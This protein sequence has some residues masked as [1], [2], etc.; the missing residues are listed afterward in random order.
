MSEP[1]R[2]AVFLD[3]DGT[4]NQDVDFLTEVEQLHILPGVPQALRRLREAGFLLI[5][6][7]NQSAIARG[8]LTEE[9]LAFIHAE[10]ERRLAAEGTRL[11]AFYY[12]PH[13]PD[14]RVER[15]ARAC[16]CRKP[17]AGLFRRAARDWGIDAAHSYA[18]GDSE[19][20]VQAG[21]TAG[22]FSIMVGG[23]RS[24]DAHAHA[25]DLAGAADIILDRQTARRGPQ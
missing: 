24:A 22:C 9:K 11:D 10:M 8:L 21:R 1:K 7:T 18:V 5:V 19:R 23:G 4:L 17:A 2:R 6:V 20:D 3:R 13:L 12:C 25:A 16:D 15:F 14:G